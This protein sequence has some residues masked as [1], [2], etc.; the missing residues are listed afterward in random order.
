MTPVVG[1]DR[2]SRNV[3]NYTSTLRD[4]PEEGGS[5]ILVLTNFTVSPRISIHY[6]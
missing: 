1:P 2:L 4:I 5:Q 3:C 6:V